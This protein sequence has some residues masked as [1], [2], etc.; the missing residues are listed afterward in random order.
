MFN[1][2]NPNSSALSR[3]GPLLAVIGIH[4]VL[5][6]VLTVSMGI[7]DLPKFAEPATVVIVPDQQEEQPE[8]EVPPVKPEI[9]QLQPQDT[10][11]PEIQYDEPVVPPSETPMPASATA[12]AATTEVAPTVAK[13][14]KTNTRVEPM[15]P[16]VSRRAGE[17]G[18]VRLK[19]LVDE[20]GRPK[21]VNVAQSSGHDR[22][23]QA[24]MDAVRKWRF[25]AA[26]NGTN[27]I[28]VWTQVAITFK[29]T[30]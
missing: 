4:V 2:R 8:P 29:L 5:G 24:A 26:T 16:P 20:S 14:L 6:Y 15:Y 9:A 13:E 21:D 12:I 7:V 10:P 11:P 17:E 25:Q 23:D 27:A 1:D 22:L 30:A 3:S 28:T 18:T 19:V